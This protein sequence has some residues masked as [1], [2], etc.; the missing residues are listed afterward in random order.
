VRVPM[1]KE[2]GQ[3]GYG[4][5]YKGLLHNKMVAIKSID[6]SKQ[7]H[8]I[9]I[10]KFSITHR[11]VQ[12]EGFYEELVHDVTFEAVIQ[13]ELKH[14]NILPVTEHWI[15]CQHLTTISLMIATD[16]CIMDLQVWLESKPFN[17]HNTT[18]FMIQISE[19]RF[20]MK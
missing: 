12:I 17:Y 2:L 4:K 16:L 3:G 19:A 10:K 15:Q 20:L 9:F 8:Q 1:I 14:D 7:Y 6:V 11:P 18:R 5:V 13:G